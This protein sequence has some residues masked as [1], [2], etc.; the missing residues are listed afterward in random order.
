MGDMVNLGLSKGPLAI[1]LVFI[2]GAWAS[3][4][5]ANSYGEMLCST[6]TQGGRGLVLPQLNAPDLVDFLWEPYPLRKLDGRIGWG[7]AKGN[8]IRSGRKTVWLE[9]EMKLKIKY[10]KNLNLKQEKYIQIEKYNYTIE[11]NPINI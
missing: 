4:L 6:L 2:T 1:G 5:E 7:R 3:L 8:G 9:C 11:N 10:L